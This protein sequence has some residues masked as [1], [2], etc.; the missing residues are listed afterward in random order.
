MAGSAEIQIF[1]DAEAQVIRAAVSGPVSAVDVR[2][3]AAQLLAAAAAHRCRSVLLDYTN[4]Q[5][6]GSPGELYDI[7]SRLDELG[8]QRTDAIAVV[9][10]PEANHQG[11]SAFGEAVAHNRGWQNIR[12]FPDTAAALAWLQARRTAA[13]SP[14]RPA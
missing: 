9:H 5:I 6:T 14:D 2:G 10:S 7:N 13:D 12:Y 1:Y 8:V 3:L 4:A 11:R